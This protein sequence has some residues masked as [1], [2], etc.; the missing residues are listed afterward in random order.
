M[1]LINSE[2]TSASSRMSTMFS[3]EL[4]SWS[5]LPGSLHLVRCFEFLCSHP[6]CG[7][8]LMM[9]SSHNDSFELHPHQPDTCVVI[10][11][12]NVFG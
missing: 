9:L 2:V 11:E 10:N 5:T 8:L 3:I 6:H 12:R 4:C 7:H 1:M